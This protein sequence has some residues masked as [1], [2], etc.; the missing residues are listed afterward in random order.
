[1]AT[2]YPAEFAANLK[3]FFNAAKSRA[4]DRAE[5]ATQPGDAKKNAGRWS[6]VFL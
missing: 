5:A 3:A 6:G 4:E 1:M 2:H